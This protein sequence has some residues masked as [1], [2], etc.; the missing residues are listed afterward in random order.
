MEFSSSF[1]PCNRE[2]GRDCMCFWGISVCFEPY[3]Q[4]LCNAVSLSLSLLLTFEAKHLR[5]RNVGASDSQEDRGES[6]GVGRRGLLFPSSS[7]SFFFFLF[8]FPVFL[9]WLKEER[10]EQCRDTFPTPPLTSLK[11]M[12]SIESS[13][14]L[15]ENGCQW[16]LKDAVLFLGIKE[17]E[18]A[19]CHGCLF[20]KCFACVRPTGN[21]GVCWICW[22]PTFPLEVIAY[23]CK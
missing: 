8:S 5:A 14:L 21:L 1:F 13:R 16:D 9:L 4:G 17:R 11:S 3:Q 12:A 2:R 23:L 15:R 22:C 7:C 18:K 6:Q 10:R 20:M 19:S